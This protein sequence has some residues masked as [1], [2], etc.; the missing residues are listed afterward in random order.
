[1][2][3]KKTMKILC[4][5]CAILYLIYSPK[6]FRNKL[7]SIALLNKETKTEYKILELWNIDTFEGGSV[8]RSS[9]LEKCA[10]LY[11]K[12]NKGQFF[13]IKNL[14]I[15]QSLQLLSENHLPAMISFGTGYGKNIKE[16]VLPLYNSYSVRNDLLNNGKIDNIQF[17]IPYILGGYSI[18]GN[19]QNVINQINKENIFVSNSKYID[20]IKVL[21]IN[22]LTQYTQENLSSFELYEGYIKNKYDLFLGTQRDVFRCLNRSKNGDIISEYKLLSGYSDLIQYLSILDNKNFK[23]CQ[24][25]LNFIISDTCQKKLCDINMFNVLKKNFYEDEFYG[26][27]EKLLNQNLLSKNAFI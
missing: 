21:E 8:S 20:P 24:N 26:N 1:M 5:V 27:F 9:F 18:I 7:S 10:I 11:E 23:L 2:K 3:N 13:I 16:L 4:M 15:E 12:N 17:A 25:F 6:I 14:T 22:N 19:N